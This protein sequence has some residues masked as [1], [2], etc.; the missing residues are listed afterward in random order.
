MRMAPDLLRGC[1]AL[2]VNFMIVPLKG[3]AK[4]P[5]TVNMSKGG[6]DSKW[7]RLSPI[8]SNPL[9]GLVMIE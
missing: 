8:P 7:T 5:F 6:P 3:A 4:V 2:L 1:L 9:V